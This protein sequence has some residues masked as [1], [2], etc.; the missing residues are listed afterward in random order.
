LARARLVLCQLAFPRN[1]LMHFLHALDAIF[2]FAL[3]LG[4]LLYHNVDA[5]RY[6]ATERGPDGHNLTDLEFMRGHGGH[7]F[8]GFPTALRAQ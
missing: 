7:P 1:A 8:V 4:K 2:E 5:A 3:V 6:V